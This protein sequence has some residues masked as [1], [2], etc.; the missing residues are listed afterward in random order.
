M[1]GPRISRAIAI[2]RSMSSSEG[3][4]WLRHRNFRLGA[5]ILHDHFL[6]M[7]ILFRAARES[8]S[9]ESMRSSIVSPMPIRIPVVKAIE[10]LPASSMVR[11]RSAGTLSGAFACG[12][13]V[14]HEA[15]ADVFEHQAD[16]GVGILEASKCSGGP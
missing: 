7:A 5:K 13:A 12:K 6:D 15:R 1:C 9:S 10:S 11:R 16:A 14:A 2:V 3:S 4:G 8:R